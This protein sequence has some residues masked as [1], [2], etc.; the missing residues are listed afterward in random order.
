SASTDGHSLALDGLQNGKLYQ[1]RVQAF[2]AVTGGTGVAN[3]QATPTD[4][5]L[6]QP[7]GKPTN[8]RV[9]PAKGMAQLCWSGVENNACVDQYRVSAVKTAEANF[10]SGFGSLPVSKGGCANISSL[11]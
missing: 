1:F 10:R 7:P 9:T 4:L 8:L 2:N 5:C 6:N 11:T 3:I